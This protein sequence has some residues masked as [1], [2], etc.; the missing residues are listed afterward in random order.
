MTTVLLTFA[1][2]ALVAAGTLALL[3]QLFGVR[4][5]PRTDVRNPTRPTG[6][7]HGAN[8]SQ[9]GAQGWRARFLD[10]IAPTMHWENDVSRLDQMDWDRYK[11]V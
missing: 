7:N 3:R 5:A 9:I 11:G 2:L 8:P 6:A 4:Q 10:R 1:A